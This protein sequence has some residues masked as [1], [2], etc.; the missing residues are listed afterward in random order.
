MPKNL[1][2]SLTSTAKFLISQAA[3]TLPTVDTPLDCLPSGWAAVW[4]RMGAVSVLSAKVT[5]SS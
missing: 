2:K 5:P 4:R 1:A 3:Q